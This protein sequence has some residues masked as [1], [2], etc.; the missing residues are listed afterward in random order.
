LRWHNHI[1][2]N[3]RFPWPLV[4]VYGTSIAVAILLFFKASPSAWEVSRENVILS[5]RAVEEIRTFIAVSSTT[6]DRATGF[7]PRDPKGARQW[8]PK[9]TAAD[10]LP[11][12][13]IAAKLFGTKEDEADYMRTLRAERSLASTLEGLADGYDI[14]ARRKNN[15]YEPGTPLF[16][17]IITFNTAEYM[18][19]GL[20]PVVDA[21][22]AQNPWADRLKELADNTL[23]ARSLWA[24]QTTISNRAEVNGDMLQTLSRL[25][26]LTGEERYLESAARIAD[27]YLSEDSLYSPGTRLRLLDHGNEVIVGL[28]EFYFI[29]AHKYPER[30]ALYKKPIHDLFDAI[31]R[32]GLKDDMVM[33]F[34]PIPPAESKDGDRYLDTWGYIMSAL[35]TVGTID[36]EDSY[37]QVVR[38]AMRAVSRQT[39]YEWEPY[40]LYDGYADALESAIVLL[41]FEEDKEL[42]DWVDQEIHT[43]WSSAGDMVEKGSFYLY[44]NVARTSIMYALMKSQGLRLYPW[45]ENGGVGVDHRN[46]KLFISFSL[47]EGK[48]WEGTLYADSA[49]HKTVWNMPENYP[50]INALPEWFTVSATGE[51]VL[52]EEGSR[53]RRTYTGAELIAGIPLSISSGDRLMLYPKH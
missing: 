24:S 43:M 10:D 47:P 29:L 6:L 40:A 1:K 35:W 16:K 3:R 39:G 27:Q 14:D 53:L 38:E 13:V 33:T 44:G 7:F 34:A 48:S 31:I 52:E 18:K 20:L 42:S 12:R 51:Y 30:A 11:Y 28:S 15:P 22:G 4:L 50:R 32:Y 21:L 41:A 26:W 19:D 9:D 37:K 45:P 2:K 5:A 17:D 23:K 36:K 8:V 46:D 25:Y 49:R